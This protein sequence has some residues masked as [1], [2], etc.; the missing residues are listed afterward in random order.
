MAYSFR[1]PIAASRQVWPLCCFVGQFWMAG[2][3][4]RG[5]EESFTRISRS[6]SQTAQRNWAIRG[7]LIGSGGFGEEV[8]AGGLRKQA[9]GFG[10][11]EKFADGFAALLAEI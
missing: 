11:D 4:N 3:V 8:H 9:C 7:R 5:A 2:W 1:N 6:S 10:A